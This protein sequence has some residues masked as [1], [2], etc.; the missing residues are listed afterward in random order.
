[1]R[2]HLAFFCVLLT[3]PL[4][5][6][7]FLQI[8]KYGSPKTKKIYIGEEITYRLNGEDSY[9]SIV[10][11]DILVD[12]N[13]LV[14]TDRYVNIG[15]INS[16]RQDITWSRSIGR[17]LFFF[18][19]GWSGFAL[20]GTL[21]DNN[22]DTSYRWSDAVVSGSALL[23]SFTLPKLFVHKKT[24]IG[25]RKRLRALDISFKVN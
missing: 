21:T 8:E 23:I 12:Q 6:Q 2:L 11:E 9:Y 5:G 25:K 15:E 24:K 22:P 13:M 14:G 20:V 4:A 18:G 7:K 16:L 19:I 1:M 17:S 3:F 10:I